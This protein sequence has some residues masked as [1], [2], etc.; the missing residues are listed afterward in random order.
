M[1]IYIYHITCI[2]VCICI[3]AHSSQHQ[4]DILC[5]MFH[6][7]VLY[8]I[9]SIRYFVYVNLCTRALLQKLQKHMFGIV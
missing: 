7:H 3:H 8:R 2:Y 5:L 4:I 6:K 9:H 1:Y